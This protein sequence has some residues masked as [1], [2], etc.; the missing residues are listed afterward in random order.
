MAK[1][2]TLISNPF[3]FRVKP[4]TFR[5][6]PK[7]T[8]HT[9]VYYTPSDLQV[10]ELCEI[11]F[12]TRQTG[13]WDYLFTGMGDEPT[14]YDVRVIKGCL[15]KNLQGRIK[16]KNPFRKEIVVAIDLFTDAK[17]A[18]VF[19]LLSE[20][21][22][23]TVKPQSILEIAF[24]FKPTKILAYYCEIHVRIDDSMKETARVQWKFPV[25]VTIPF[26]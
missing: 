16:F 15:H 13:N 17:S 6:P 19:D 3:C 23:Y 7:S 12:E 9:Y 14:P 8:G 18:E 10:K 22:K 5:I 1:F 4:E 26:I 20:K 25:K 11:N 24:T 2:T 21:D